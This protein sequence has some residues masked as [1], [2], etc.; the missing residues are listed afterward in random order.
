MELEEAL[1]Q[2]SEFLLAELKAQDIPPEMR[3]VIVAAM[4][5]RAIRELA[6]DALSPSTVKDILEAID[7]I[8]YE[9]WPEGRD[10]HED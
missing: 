9:I 1:D 6:P 7:G 5:P 3:V 8:L 10:A 2:I 4:L